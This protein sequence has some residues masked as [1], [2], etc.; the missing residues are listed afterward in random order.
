MPRSILVVL[1]L[2]V[3]ACSSPASPSAEPLTGTWVGTAIASPGGSGAV[4]LTLV[5]KATD[6]SGTLTVAFPTLE[7]NDSGTVTGTLS[8]SAAAPSRR[9][10]G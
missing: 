10:G 1:C 4:R 3:G 2:A 5:Q 6:V 8:G 7:S 9:I